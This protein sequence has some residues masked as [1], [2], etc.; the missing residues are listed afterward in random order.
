M[1]VP[2]PSLCY[3]L[4]VLEARRRILFVA[5]SLTLAQVVR[6]V[7]LARRLDPRRYEVH[8]ACSE[9]DPLVFGDT[10]FRRWPLFSIDRERG[11]AALAKGDRLYDAATL[12]RY[13]EDELSLFGEVKPDL[14]VGDFRLSLAVSAPVAKV[15]HAALINAYWSPYAVR[16][17]FPVPDHPIVS[18]VG[19]ERAARYLPQALPRAFAHFAAPLEAVRKRFGLPPTG[20]LLE[21]LT[22]GDY[23]LYPDIPELCPTRNT[24]QSHVYLGAIAWAPSVPL[25]DFWHDLDPARPLIYVTLGS[26][27]SLPTLPA[28]LQAIAQLPVQAVLA[29]AGRARPRD[30][31]DN[32]RVVDFVPGHVVARRAQLVISNGGSSTGYQALAEGVPV[33]GVPFNM[34]QYLAMTAIERAGAG[35]LV[36]AGSIRP[37]LVAT[38][39]TAILEDPR[40][41]EAARQLQR[42]FAQLDCH[43]RFE[44]VLTR[45]LG[46]WTARGP[47]TT[48]SG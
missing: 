38:A 2:A 40:P 37:H 28:V 44:E 12:A 3:T 1:V 33:L 8:F 34:D 43:A 31:P 10:E 4:R 5:E 29:G 25:P 17:V 13:V 42:G 18:L 24:P 21:Q 9:F 48:I 32:V 41:R 36:R 45:A 35:R 26:S 30:V 23:T 20:G 11:L 14:V 15:A 47:G 39:I 16:D 27:G 46:P 19:V 7:A 22:F 6:L